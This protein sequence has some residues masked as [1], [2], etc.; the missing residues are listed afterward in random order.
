[1][2]ERSVGCIK[3]YAFSCLEKLQ[4]TEETKINILFK[5]QVC[6]QTPSIQTPIR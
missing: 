3:N 6:K 1:M 2:V 5:H 4:K